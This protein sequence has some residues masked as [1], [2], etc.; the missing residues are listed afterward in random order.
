M[1]CWQTSDL[2][3]F[4][5]NP[6][7]RVKRKGKK[8]TN[9]K[10]HTR[11]HKREDCVTDLCQ[12]GVGGG[13]DDFRADVG[14]RYIDKTVNEEGNGSVA[15]EQRKPRQADLYRRKRKMRKRRKRQ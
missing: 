1:L 2:F 11:S 15:K 7:R 13:G 14:G 12:I 9:K 8:Q 4:L 5:L 6:I 10:N 3:F